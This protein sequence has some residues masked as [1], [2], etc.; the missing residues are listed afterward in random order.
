MVFCLKITV[1]GIDGDN[2]TR[3]IGMKVTDI[4]YNNWLWGLTPQ[5]WGFQHTI[6]MREDSG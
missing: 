1:D 3:S 2:R 6:R 5:S 4:G